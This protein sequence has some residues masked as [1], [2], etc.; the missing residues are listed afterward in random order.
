MAAAMWQQ[1]LD[2]WDLYLEDVPWYQSQ[3][4]QASW[5]DVP[6]WSIIYRRP[7]CVLIEGPLD[8]IT[9]SDV[10]VGFKNA[11]ATAANV[12]ISGAG[13]SIPTTVP[14]GGYALTLGDNC[15]PM[16]GVVFTDIRVSGDVVAVLAYFAA[17]SCFYEFCR[18]SWKT[19]PLFSAMGYHFTRRPES[20]VCQD[21]PSWT[22]P[23]P[24]RAAAKKRLQDQYLR[25]LMAVACHPSRILQ[26]GC[27]LDGLTLQAAA[28]SAPSGAVFTLTGLQFDAGLP[29]RNVDSGRGS[30][31]RS[32]ACQGT[33]VSH[34]SLLGLRVCVVGC[35][36]VRPELVRSELHRGRDFLW[37][38]GRS[39][40]RELRVRRD[41][42]SYPAMDDRADGAQVLGSGQPPVQPGTEHKLRPVH[43]LLR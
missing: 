19:G 28:E 15:I 33:L 8:D 25:E 39:E 17:D 37:K 2:E 18:G 12:S 14:A 30:A 34:G 43:R 1:V 21:L 32:S 26:I 22:P 35:D 11:G 3:I 41:G 36:G 4:Q 9:K 13:W 16:L 20:V 29:D 24:R 5:P 10:L 23:W 42:G 6:P 31:Y 7:G 38:P 27:D 40:Q